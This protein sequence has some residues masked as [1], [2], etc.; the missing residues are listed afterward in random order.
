MDK[1]GNLLHNTGDI[2]LRRR[3]KWIIETLKPKDGEHILDLGC[4]DGFYLYLLS[5]LELNT[6]LYGVDSDKHALNS[7]MKNLKIDEIR[8]TQADLMKKLPFNNDF[9]DAIVMSE[10]MEHLPDEINGM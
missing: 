4:G 3:A 1:L 10:V 9:F 6:I 8:L 5:N 7:A 2:A